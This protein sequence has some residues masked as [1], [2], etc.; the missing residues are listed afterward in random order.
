MRF[1]VDSSVFVRSFVK[2]EKGHAE[3]ERLRGRFARK[4]LLADCPYLVL[5][6]TVAAV[7]R[8]EGVEEARDAARALMRT[9]DFTAPDADLHL[10]AMHHAQRAL[11]KGADAIIVAHAHKRGIP[12]VTVDDEQFERGK[13][14]VETLR[15]E[16]VR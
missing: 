7:A 16:E 1:C 11:L 2:K 9:A 10:A 8:V 4:D 15:P 5:V 14:I 13:M 6:E 12:L 3:A